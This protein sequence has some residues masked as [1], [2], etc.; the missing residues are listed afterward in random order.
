MAQGYS[1]AHL[2]ADDGMTFVVYP[3]SSEDESEEVHCHGSSASG[4]ELTGGANSHRDGA[5][6]GVGLQHP[7]GAKPELRAGPSPGGSPEGS[8][9]TSR[10]RAREPTLE[11]WL[12]R[13]LNGEAIEATDARRARHV[14]FRGKA[15]GCDICGGPCPEGY[16]AKPEHSIVQKGVDSSD[17]ERSGESSASDEPYQS[18]EENCAVSAFERAVEAH[19]KLKTQAA[20]SSQSANTNTGLHSVRAPPSKRRK[21]GKKRPTIP[22]NFG[23]IPNWLAVSPTIGK[24]T[25]HPSHALGYH[26]GLVWCWSCGHY[27]GTVPIKLRG[28]CNG[29]TLAGEQNLHRLRNAKP[30]QKASWPLPEFPQNQ[31]EQDL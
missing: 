19:R 9:L 8:F 17:G 13:I 10:K 23:R 18:A 27:G 5:V 30:P 1:A 24:V 16:C 26:R 20:S 12:T 14:R 29:L 22:E 6:A 3:M 28:E 2:S 15:S 21:A 11:D 31:F 4:A 7:E 25:L